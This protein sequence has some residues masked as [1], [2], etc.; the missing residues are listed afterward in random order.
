MVSQEVTFK[1]FRWVPGCLDKGPDVL[2]PAKKI[3][4]TKNKKVTG[5]K[6]QQINSIASVHDVEDRDWYFTG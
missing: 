6:I 2:Q 4:E 3:N 5:K 1:S